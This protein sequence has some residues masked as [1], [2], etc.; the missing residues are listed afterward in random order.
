MY[1]VEDKFLCSVPDMYILQSKISSV[2]RH[3][4]NSM[5]RSGYKITSVYFDDYRDSNLSDTVDGVAARKKY[6]ARIYNDSFEC[7]KLEVKYKLNS[8]VYKR[9][10]TINKEQLEQLMNGQPITD[11]N[12]NM[13]NPLTMFNLA[14]KQDMLM[15]KVIVEYDRAAYVYSAGNVRITFDRA[16]RSSKD[17]ARFLD[18][19]R[20]KYRIISD[21]NQVLEVKYDQ[22]VPGF[23]MQLLENGNMQQ[24]TFSKYQLCRQNEEVIICQ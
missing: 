21:V 16:V 6:R 8:R 15:P 14:I 23:I 22:F 7:I 12:P 4:S 18:N 9:T 11:D 20:C 13:D 17:F 3:D 10:A 1:R 5:S 19:N 24:I 2:L